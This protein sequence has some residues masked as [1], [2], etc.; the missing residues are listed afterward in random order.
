MDTLISIFLFL[1]TTFEVFKNLK[2]F[3]RVWILNASNASLVCFYAQVL[4]KKYTDIQLNL[5]KWR[6][7]LLLGFETCMFEF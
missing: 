4:F 1:K 3:Q 2:K 5:K 6:A 7:H